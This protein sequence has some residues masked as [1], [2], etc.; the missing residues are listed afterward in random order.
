ME[1]QI[2]FVVN[3]P[4]QLQNRVL[5]YFIQSGFKVANI[6]ENKLQFA[7]SGSIFDNWKMNPLHWGCEITVLLQDENVMADFSINTDSHMNTAE[8]TNVWMVFINNFKLFLTNNI[9]FKTENEKAV[10]LVKRSIADYLGWMILGFAA[11]VLID[12]MFFKLT[13]Y[14]MAF[15]IVP[16]ISIFF[17]NNR[18]RYKKSRRMLQ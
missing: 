7:H 15:V 17:L 9:D 10:A 6:S 1:R 8:Q 18:I 11:G 13:G 14:K 5:T 2:S 4:V 16:I 12:V 3:N